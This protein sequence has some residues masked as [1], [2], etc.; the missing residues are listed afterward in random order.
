MR[1]LAD[2][3]VEL[4]YIE[5]ISHESVRKVLKEN[6]IKPWQK[7]EWCIP[8]EENAEFV[9]SMENVLEVY[10]KPYDEAHPVVCMDESSKQQI[11][12][13]RQPTIDGTRTS[14]ML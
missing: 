6:E 8:P 11:K 9:C 1:L 7:K 10:K 13:V 12:E 5:N 2:K 4:E 14:K 3:M